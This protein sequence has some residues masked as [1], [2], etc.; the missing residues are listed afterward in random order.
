MIEDLFSNL[1][2][3]FLARHFFEHRVLQQ[4]LLNEIGQ[5]ERRHLQHLDAL[6]Q[7]WRQ[8]K[9]LGKAGG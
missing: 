3:F 7:L 2:H 4:L 5:L 1:L 6:P 9:S 8:Y